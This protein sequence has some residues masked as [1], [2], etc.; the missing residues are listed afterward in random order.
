MHALIVGASP[1]PSAFGDLVSLAEAASIV[2]ACDGGATACQRT[3]VR[4][5]IVVGDMDS[6][7]AGLEPESLADEVRAFPT[8]KNQSDLDLGL[9]TVREMGAT[10][11]TLTGVTGGRYDHTLAAL[12]TLMRAADMAPLLITE[13]QECALLSVEY[14]PELSI[15]GAGRHF[16]IVAVQG[17]ARVSCEGARY[18]LENEPID[19]FA[20]L[21]LSNMV[22]RDTAR[23]RVHSGRILLVADAYTQ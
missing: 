11:V 13:S 15:P 9:H 16:S 10:S 5:D 23:V 1:D 2:V 22:E 20:S 3:G 7:P 4:P 21:G 18:S 19:S 14:C 6:I 17:V 8:D 12:G